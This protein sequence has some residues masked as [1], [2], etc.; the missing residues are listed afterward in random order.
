[1]KGEYDAKKQAVKELERQK[2]QLDEK[3]KPLEDLKKEMAS[4][5]LPLPEKVIRPQL[6]LWIRDDVPAR[7]TLR[8]E[9]DS[10]GDESSCEREWWRSESAAPQVDCGGDSS[11]GRIAGLDHGGGVLGSAEAEREV[12]RRSLFRWATHL[13][14]E[15]TTR[16][17]TLVSRVLKTREVLVCSRSHFEAAT[18]GTCQWSET[19]QNA[20]CFNSEVFEGLHDVKWRETKDLSTGMVVESRPV[21]DKMVAVDDVLPAG[22]SNIKTTIWYGQLHQPKKSKPKSRQHLAKGIQWAAAVFLL[23]AMA[24]LSSGA[25]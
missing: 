21:D 14:G 19:T 23:E 17:K 3:L 15:A 13:F 8:D 10:S 6:I 18:S 25:E 1:M 22:V 24:L 20:T 11:S 4:R 7:N 12:N 2:K 5:E 16:S 9:S